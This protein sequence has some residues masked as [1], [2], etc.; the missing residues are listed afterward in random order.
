VANILITGSNSG[1]GRLAVLTLARQGHRVVATMRTVSKGDE[2]RRLAEDEGLDIEVRHLDV[3][4]P[5]SIGAAMVDPLDIDVLVNNAGFEVQGAIEQ[6]DDVLMH[7]QL[8]TNVMGPLRT[9]RAVLPA[10]S[11]RGSGVVVNVSSIAGRVA[12]PYSGAYA[13]SKHALEALSESLHFEVSHLGLRV[14]LI[15][16]GRFPTNFHDNIVFPPSWGGSSHEDRAVAF[17]ESLTSLDGGGA[18]ADPQAVADAIARAAID[19]STPFRT[20]VGGDAELIDATKAS[21]SFEDFEATMRNAL[22]W[23]D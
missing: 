6:V 12:P 11:Q 4:D 13:A 18:P 22:D 2:L 16:P 19:P 21:M 20:L 3:T 8:E 10:W 9:M 14:H 7:R 5:G 1:F 23:H 17:R 15:E